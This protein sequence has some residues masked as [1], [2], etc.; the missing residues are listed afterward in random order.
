MK[1][2]IYRTCKDNPLPTQANPNDAGWDVYAA[3]DV[4]FLQG[5]TIMVSLGIIAQAP[6]GFHFKLCI[7]SS[8]S[9]KGFLLA[10]GVGIVDSKFCGPEDEMKMILRAP[11]RL[12]YPPIIIKKGQRIGQ[13]ILEKNND[14]EWDEQE[15]RNF[16]GESR[17]GFGS[18]G[19]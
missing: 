19:E 3:E 18:T 4:E 1:I 2:K 5:Q 17:G 9:R 16:G 15:D 7:R 12:N 6:K 11:E 14:I 8:L 13:L 10:N